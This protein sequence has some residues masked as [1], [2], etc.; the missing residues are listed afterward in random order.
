MDL[1]VQA[2]S[3][4]WDKPGAALVLTLDTDRGS[5]A[6]RFPVGHVAIEWQRQLHLL[7]VHLAPEVGD[8]LESVEGFFHWL[9]KAG[10]TL[11]RGLKKV[12]KAVGSRLLKIGKAIAKSK[13][14]GAALGAVATVFPAVGGPALAAWVVANR[15]VAAAEAAEKAAKRIKQ[16]IG[17]AADLL[18]VKHGKAAAHQLKQLAHD[19]RPAARLLVAAVHAVP[20]A[21]QR[22]T[23]IA[24]MHQHAPPR[25]ATVHAISA[26]THA[27]KGGHL[28][29]ATRA[30][31]IAAPRSPA[32]ARHLVNVSA[33]RSEGERLSALK[34]RAKSHLVRVTHGAP[35]QWTHQAAQPAPSYESYLTWLR[36]A[37]AA[38]G[39]LEIGDIEIA[40]I[41]IGAAADFTPARSYGA[42]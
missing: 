10:K 33:A 13:L 29:P 19:K 12:G 26:P 18:A 38:V 11:G 8:D 28:A 40:D 4:Q 15:V 35:T 2:F 14:V 37:G 21:A 3:F 27:A 42:A 9:K 32:V 30:A 39:D 20:T 1:V 34:Q 24:A 17:T 7:G 5:C 16:G 36:S 31:A 41:E 23:E 22:A 25:L 6:I